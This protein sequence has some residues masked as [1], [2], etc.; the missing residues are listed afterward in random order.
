[1]RI[2]SLSETTAFQTELASAEKIFF[3]SSSKKSFLTDEERRLFRH[4]YFGTYVDA[5]PR[6]FLLALDGAGRVLGYLAG[7]PETRED[8]YRLNPYL[9]GFRPAIAQYPAHLH[10]NFAPEAR[11]LGLG[12]SLLREFER[13][14]E[15]DSVQGVHLVTGSSER[16]V[17]FYERNGYQAASRLTIGNSELLLLGK[18]L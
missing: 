13:R 1:M 7:T 11:G 12:S 16:N 15:G 9:E 17:G 18:W 14:L 6:W 2:H 8:H 4:R 3:E 10:I 5:D